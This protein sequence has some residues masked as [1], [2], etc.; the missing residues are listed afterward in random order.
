M[1]V[2][3]RLS[4]ERQLKVYLV[5]GTV[6]ELLRG[7]SAPDVDLAVDRE[8]LGLA[9]SL[10]HTLGAT[11]VLLDAKEKTAR[12]VWQGRE[13]DFA[14]F[15][16]PDL[17]ADLGKRDFTINALAFP[18][19]SVMAGETLEIIDPWGGQADLA[20]G[21]L[22]LLAPENF[23][24]D[25]LR[26]LRAFR[27]A[28]THSLTL[29]PETSTAIQQFLPE[30]GRVAGERIHYELFRL[31]EA[32]RAFPSLQQMDQAGLLCR[33]LPELADL[34]GVQQ[35]GF[36]HLDVFEHSMAAVD[37]LEQVIQRPKDYFSDLADVVIGYAEMPKKV[38]LLKLAALFHDVGKPPTQE[39][40]HDPDRY[41]FYYHDQLGVELFSRAAERLRF[42]VEEIRTV[43][44]L[45]S[46]H[47][48]PFLLLPIFRQGELSFR[49]LGRLIRVARPELPGMFLLAMADSL[50][51]QGAL[52]PQDAELV[53]SDFCE[54]VYNFLKERVEPLE[55]RPRLITGDDLIREFHLKPGPQFG[56]LLEEVEEACLEG[57]IQNRQ[58]ALDLVRRKVEAE[59]L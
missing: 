21:R 35:N 39:F 43:S 30:M 22:H 11:Y 29:T 7:R 9:Q 49:A 16:A 25:P 18:L 8:A 58:E 5:G 37:H 51:G 14:E 47:M 6:R 12:V 41:T 53:L 56:L 52:K 55:K 24:D 32:P 26:L 2:L 31:L 17:I 34:K 23:L 46:L 19:S 57:R 38:V 44:L 4:Q 27:F 40:R 54:L 10:A 3:A 48:R 28:A 15:R 36:H 45:I 20:A 59:H 13:F 1:Q 33:I 42:S 50:A